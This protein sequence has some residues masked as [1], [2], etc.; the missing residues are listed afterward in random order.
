[1]KVVCIHTTKIISYQDSTHKN[2]CELNKVYDAELVFNYKEDDWNKNFLMI[3]GFPMTD[4]FD[5]RHFLPLDEWRHQQ[6]SKLEI[7]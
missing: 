4:W 1:M 5:C 6:L 2:H 7:K 3:S